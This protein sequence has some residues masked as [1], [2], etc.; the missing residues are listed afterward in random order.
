M[1][2]AVG[3]TLEELWISYNQIE[4]LKGINVLKKLRVLYMANNAVKEWVEF[5]KLGDLP[6]LEDIVFVGPL[7]VCA[8]AVPLVTSSDS[9][10]P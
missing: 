7:I 5:Q 1:Q 2:E 10:Q 3:D 4:K 9:H 8:C 6:C